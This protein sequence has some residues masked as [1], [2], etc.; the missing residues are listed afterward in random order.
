MRIV[1]P[2]LLLAGS[3]GSCAFFTDEGFQPVQNNVRLTANVTYPSDLDIDGPAG[4]ANTEMDEQGYELAYEWE[5]ADGFAPY[6]QYGRGSWT[7][8]WPGKVDFM[9]WTAGA[10]W[11]TEQLGDEG[12]WLDNTR[13]FG[14]LG[15]SILDPDTFYDGTESHRFHSALELKAGTGLQRHLHNG[16]F[17]ELGLLAHLGQTQEVVR[18]QVALTSAENDWDWYRLMLTIGVGVRF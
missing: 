3:L 14:D 9:R 16:V 11:Y 1:L 17:F 2:A 13:A 6:V 4:T 15:L 10:R 12:G 18:D 7:F 5:D 8:D